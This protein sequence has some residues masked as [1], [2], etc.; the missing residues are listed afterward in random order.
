MSRRRSLAATLLFAAI[1]TPPSAALATT[2]SVDRSNALCSDLGPGSEIAPFCTINKARTLATAGDLVLVHPA[3]Y[4]EQVAPSASGVAGLP[5]TYR[6]SGSG[7]ILLGTDDLSDAAGW[8]TTTTSA[9]SRSFAPSS[10]PTQVFVD[11][12]RL[13]LAT[14]AGTTT[15]GSFFYDAIARILYVD[16]GG[17]NPADGHVVEAGARTHGFNIVGRSHIVVEGFDIRRQNNTGMRLASMSSN[18]QIL[19]NTTS[20]TGVN[21]ILSDTGVGPIRIEGNEVST[22]GSVGIRLLNSNGVEL[23]GNV[24]HD[25]GNHGLALQGSAGNLIEGNV[26]FANA[27][28]TVRAANGLDVNGVSPD[29]VIRAN[30]FFDNQD[31]GCQVYNGSHNNLVVRNISFRNGDH[32]FDTNQSTGTRYVSNTSYG[33]FKDGF[34][35]EGLSTGTTLENN[36]AMNNGLTTNEF[37]LFVDAGS[38]P[39]FA[40]DYNIFH[41]SVP[42]TVVKFNLALYAT[43]GGFAGTGNE[44]NGIGADPLF[45]DAAAGDLRLRI[46][47][48]VDSADTAT[49]GFAM[50]DHDGNGPMDLPGVADTGV[51]P[52]T[53]ADR[54]ALER[55]DFPPEATLQIRK[56]NGKAPHG[57]SADASHSG[58]DDRIVSYTF[59]FGNG[60]VIGP[61]PGSQ[62]AITYRVP[63]EFT[64]R[65]TVVDTAGFSA[66]AKKKVK[67]R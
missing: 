3:V 65:V 64:V 12:D 21:G 37:E 39:G 59:D 42:G 15:P 13:A 2:W 31:S 23:V 67:I 44:A 34:S 57:V 50:P 4:R 10:A 19:N 27:R 17:P 43:L 41:K 33:N 25:N 26:S 14:A 55:R 1:L 46:G 48:A 40:S 29:N 6:A 8:S 60:V 22:A 30:T 11:G 58:D 47:P 66:S 54:G 16:L 62:A 53:F 5:I 38:L 52:V 9:W 32:G 51:G 45:V 20:Q 63:G 36:I 61:Q 7:V 28:P 49:A 24:S 35:V 18:L 56:P